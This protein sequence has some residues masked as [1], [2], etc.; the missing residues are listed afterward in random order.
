MAQ[1]S[2]I[3]KTF[4]PSPYVK[5]SRICFARYVA[6]YHRDDEYDAQILTIPP[7]GAGVTCDGHLFKKY[8]LWLGLHNE[9]NYSELHCNTGPASIDEKSPGYWHSS[10]YFHGFCYYEEGK[11]EKVGHFTKVMGYKEWCER[12]FEAI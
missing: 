3:P 11:D 9:D 5:I 10:W 8:T 12:A 2:I 1:A 7:A 6:V 4:Q